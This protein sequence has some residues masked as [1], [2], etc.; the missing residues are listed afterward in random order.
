LKHALTFDLFE[1]EL[2]FS[3]NDPEAFKT[4]ITIDPR[5]AGHWLASSR[6]DHEIEPEQKLPVR[7]YRLGIIQS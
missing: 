7:S 1:G 6:I 2:T 5:S 3:S 4:T